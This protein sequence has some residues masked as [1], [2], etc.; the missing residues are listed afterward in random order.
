ME[1]IC[2]SPTTRHEGHSKLI[3][4]VDGE[5]VKKAYFI[6]TTPIRGFETIVKGKPVEFAPIAVMRICGICQTTHG[7]ASC[8]AIEH[9]MGIEVP[10][11]GLLLRELVGLGNRMHSHPLHHLLTLDDFVKSEEEKIELIKLI[12]KMRKVGQYIVDVV[13]GEGIHPPNIVIGGMRNNI[14]ER[15]KSKIYYALK[16]FEKDAKVLY[17]KYV[18]LV[19]NFLEETGIP[20]LGSHEFSYLATH[21]TY[22][23][24]YA[25]NWDDVTEILPQRYYDNKEVGTSTSIMIPLYGGVPVEV[26]PRARLSKFMGFKVKGNALEINIARAQ[27]NLGAVYRAFDILDELNIHGKTRADYEYKE[28]VGIGVHEAPRGTNV[29]MVETSKDGK[30]K[31]Y[32]ITAAST[33]NFP[34]VEKAIEGYPYKYAEVILR[35]YDI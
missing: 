27:E 16:E 9:A 14:T 10:E 33:W 1:S 31:A 24:R 35:A 7:I 21:T 18:E 22:G 3:L 2:I 8:E 6:N 20:D 23:D 4:E 26:G 32:R 5:I 17:E 19:E 12:Q 11:D 30:V 13:G 15:A 25:I 29:H 28:G 34:V